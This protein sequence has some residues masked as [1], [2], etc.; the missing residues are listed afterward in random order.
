MDAINKLEPHRTMSLQGFNDYG[1]AAALWGA[2][3]TGFT[4]SGIFRD[5]ADFAVLTLFEKD[6]PFGHPRFSYLPNGNFTGL[7]LDFDI[8][9]QGIQAFESKKWPW[10]DWL[11]LDCT[12]G[13]GQTVQQSL[14][15]LATGPSER[16]GASG[17]FTL[18]S[19]TVQ[20]GDRVTLWY[21]NQAFDYT[22]PSFTSSCQ[23][24]MWWQGNSGYQHSVTIAGSVYSVAENGLGSADIATNIAGQI[25]SSDPNCTA[26]T[27]SN[28]LTLTLKAGVV[29][30]VTVSSSDG[31]GSA[32][33]SSV[34]PQSI[35]ANIASQI[36]ATNWAVNGP[37]ALSAVASGNQIT[38][39]AEPGADGNMATFYELHKNTNLYFTP[40]AVQ[41]AG[42]SSDNVKWH[43]TIDF[44]A[45]AGP[46]FRSSG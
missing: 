36:N 25:N 2:S 3:E 29:G 1:A 31:S 13:N 9:W 4:V 39:T 5:Q 26:A 27:S 10:T 44:S 7:K 11:Y 20:P 16:T 15:Q 17:T 14:A 40:A 8:E 42:G 45:L 24:A 43:V 46:T 22:V 41:L 30:P 6:D 32:T 23:Q 28:I 21:Q 18:N 34:T 33:L 38:I 35:C 37:V 19:G 12:L